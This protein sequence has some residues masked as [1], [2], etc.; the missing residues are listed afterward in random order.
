MPTK[1]RKLLDEIHEVMRIG[2]YSLHTER[3]YG[4]WIKRFIHFHNMKSRDDLAGGE[5][6]IEQY[7]THLAV[8]GNVSPATQ[9]QAMNALIFLYKKVIKQTLDG[10]INAVRAEQKQNIP[11]V[12]SKEEVASVISLMKGTTQLVVK[13]LYGSGLR[14]IRPLEKVTLLGQS[15]SCEWQRSS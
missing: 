13:L 12:L 5:A 6:K 1:N 2:H 4:D 8:N 9:N 10:Q 7:L 15:Q 3:A 11:V 14:I